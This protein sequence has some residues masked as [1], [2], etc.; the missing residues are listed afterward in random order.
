[1]LFKRTVLFF[2]T[3][4][5]KH[6]KNPKQLDI[7]EIS[8]NKAYSNLW[9]ISIFEH[10]FVLSGLGGVSLFCLFYFLVVIYVGYLQ[11]LL[12]FQPTPPYGFLCFML[13]YVMFLWK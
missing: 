2:E 5:Q 11:A 6:W 4:Y 3:H 7:S 13:F 12:A 1:M 9:L 10:A 8:L